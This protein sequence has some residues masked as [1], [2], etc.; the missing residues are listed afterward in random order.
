MLA[1]VAG[2]FVLARRAAGLAAAVAAGLLVAT[3][4]LHV[5]WAQAVMSDVP[6]GAAVA[7]IAV[8][9]VGAAGRARLLETSA[10]GVA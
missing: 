10:L 1:A 5:L 6:A 3:S 8:D 2:T 7:W 4:R 9:G